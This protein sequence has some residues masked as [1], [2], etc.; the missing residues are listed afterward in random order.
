MKYTFFLKITQKR[1][2]D[3]K[4]VNKKD[5]SELVSKNAPWNVVCKTFKH[6]TFKPKSQR[7]NL[8]TTFKHNI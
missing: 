2:P 8:N 4:N 3:D 6:T 5:K 7:L 1:W